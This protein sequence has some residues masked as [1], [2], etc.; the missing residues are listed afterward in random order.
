MKK[1]IYPKVSKAESPAEPVSKFEE[2]PES[3]RAERDNLLQV[4][5]TLQENMKILQAENENYIHILE[6]QGRRYKNLQKE[7]EDALRIDIPDLNEELLFRDYRRM[8][9]SRVLLTRLAMNNDELTMEELS[10]IFDTIDVVEGATLRNVA[11]HYDP[12]HRE[13]KRLRNIKNNKIDAKQEEHDRELED[14]DDLEDVNV[15][16]LDQ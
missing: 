14:E 4:V 8:A 11:R 2:L 10:L 13:A 1:G 7:T 16:D 3:I 12:I 15:A 5:Q 6:R 9:E